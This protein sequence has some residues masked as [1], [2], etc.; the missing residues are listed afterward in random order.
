M[1]LQP[2]PVS[3][4]DHHPHQKAGWPEGARSGGATDRDISDQLDSPL[5]NRLI[6]TESI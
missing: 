2:R 5:R 6:S 3:A 4:F 1:D